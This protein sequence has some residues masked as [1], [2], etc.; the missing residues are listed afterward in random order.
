MERAADQKSEGSTQSGERVVDIGMVEDRHEDELELSSSTEAFL[1][2][3][4]VVGL[5]R[6]VGEGQDPKRP[7]SDD[8][9]YVVRKRAQIHAS[10]TPAPQ[11]AQFRMIRDPQNVSIHFVFEPLAQAGPS[12]FVVGDNVQ[13]FDAGFGEER[14]CHGARR[15]WAS[16]MTSS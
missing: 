9:G 4:P 1:P 10:I 13:E 14:N 8:V 3:D 7:A 16:R 12:T 15:F 5:T 2:L 11:P 6:P